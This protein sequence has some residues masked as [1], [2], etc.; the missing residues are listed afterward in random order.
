MK[1]STFRVPR[2]AVLLAIPV[3]AGA[4]AP[5]VGTIAGASP[6]PTG[7]PGEGPM[8]YT[9]RPTEAGITTGDLMSRLYVVA[10][11]SMMGREAG[12]VGNVKGTDYIAAE[13]RRMGLEP[14]GDNGTFFQTIPL[15]RRGAN[16]ASAIVVDGGG[17]LAMGTDFA[18]IP[19]VDG[20]FPFGMQMRGSS[21]QVVYGGE[22]G[23]EMITP[24]QAAG[25]FV[26][27]TAPTAQFWAGGGLDRYRD[28]A[29]IAFATLEGSPPGLLDF[30][31]QPQVTLS[32]ELSYPLGMTVTRAAA[33]RLMGRPLAGLKAGT[34][35]KAVRSTAG[36]TN[37]PT[38]APAR[39]VIAI[40]RGTDPTLRGQFVAVGAHND[41]VGIEDEVV[42]HDSLRAHNAV[43]RPTG[44][45]AQPRPATAEE[46]V[47]IRA[48]LDSLRSL[49]PARADSIANGADDDASGTVA[50][51]EI[52]EAMT[53]GANRPK[54]SM[55]FVW[56]TAEELGLFGSEHFSE[57]PTV[58]RDSIVAQLNIDMIGRGRAT[59]LP[60]AGPGYVQ[61][62]GSRR[63]S[64]ELG[65]LVE[66][67]NTRG[68][69]GMRFDYQYDADGHPS[70]YYCRSDHY[71]YARWGIPVAFFTTGGHRDY[72]QVT[73][74]AQ[75]VDFEQLG[76]VT[77]FILAV[78][79]DVANLDH[80]P[81]VDKPK[82]DPYGT[83]KQ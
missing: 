22:I 61:M 70:N 30:F 63:L 38:E 60:N 34:A 10:D 82:P 41:H 79:T 71:N 18:L 68:N 37:V 39:N 6:A 51:L 57:H 19:H 28:A 17:S 66:S 59:D 35:G 55:L 42:D 48:M 74:E 16:P 3:F 64:T 58:P 26:V 50:V 27:F 4:C 25:K 8:K 56:H 75:Y 78:A 13:A 15:V 11:D 21:A 54:R 24:A 1:R 23:G 81:V 69:H 36:F 44:A 62:I 7:M 76:R 43:V 67:T 47:R 33:E 2:L 9:A 77:R 65:D 29:G 53:R 52:A 14:A 32:K 72:H 45:D 83:C 73:D 12:T 5:S 20:Y 31:R 40:L 49:R 80:R 46:A